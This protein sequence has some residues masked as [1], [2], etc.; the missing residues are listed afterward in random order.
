METTNRKN[1]NTLDQNKS[2]DARALTMSVKDGIA[3]IAFDDPDKK[4]NTLNSKL[5]PLIGEF[6]KEIESS[7][8]IQGAVILSR[9][10]GCFI[11]GADIEELRS[12]K[13]AKE[14]ESLSRKGQEVFTRIENSKKPVVAAISGACL[15]GGLELALACHYRIASDIPS[16]VLG[17]P[18]VMLGL[19]PGARGTQRLPRLLGLEKALS[20]MLTGSPVKA[21][22][23]LRMGLVDYVSY[24]EDLEALAIQAAQRL[25]KKNLVR[26]QKKKKGLSGLLESSSFGQKFIL[27]KAKESVEAKT[28]GLYPAPLVLLKVIEY[29]LVNSFEQGLQKEAEEFGKLSQ[30]PEARGLISLYFAQTELKKN[31]FGKPAQPVKTI[32]VLGAGL[33]GAGIASVSIQKGMTARIKDISL[34][35]LGKGKKQIW[36]ELD[37]KVQRKSLTAFQRDQTLSHLC[38][39]TDLHRFETCDLIVEAVFEEMELKHRVLKEV[40]PALRDDAVFASNTSALPISEIAKYSNRKDRILGMHYF[41]PVPKM[42]LLEIIVTDE[43]SKEATALAVDTGLRQGKTVIVVKDG[44]GFYTTR[45]LGPYMDEAALLIREGYGIRELDDAMQLFGYPVGPIK[46]IDEV[47]IDVAFHVGDSLG[48]A[49]GKRMSAQ[50]PTLLQ[51]FIKNKWLGRKSGKG[52]YLYQD[53]KGALA[54]LTKKSSRTV[55]LEAL[56]L[57]EKFKVKPQKMA[58]DLSDTQKRV[59]Y[60]MVNEAIFCLQEGILST[61]TDG[62]AGAVFGLGFPPFTGGPFRY[63]DTKGVKKV[64]DEMKRFAEIFGER[65]A[66]C[67]LL[68]DMANGGKT[69]Y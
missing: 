19:L 22:K 30:T 28:R 57:V 25:A 5:I 63:V 7:P 61:P 20:M 33:M 16:T 65:F 42:P 26:R 48:K 11:A 66:P 21:S 2:P 54:A 40:E 46:L 24:A 58:A 17:A 43:T 51:E 31:R 35:A 12:A 68:V 52:F 37:S 1:Q 8:S 67:P 55:N 3:V 59:A 34:N 56:E 44:P 15:G 41:S 6:L 10:K 39:Q 32:G 47:G 36:K 23:A 38:L 14:V 29:G 45:I 49:F 18:E 60:R 13:N 64:A 50:E 4:V 62:D 9:K 27:K 53:K 69:F